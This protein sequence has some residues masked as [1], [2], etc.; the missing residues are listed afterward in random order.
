MSRGFLTEITATTGIPAALYHAGRTLHSFIG[1]VVHYKDNDEKN[2]K[3]S[4]VGSR[5]QRADVFKRVPLLMVDHGSFLDRNLL[6]MDMATLGDLRIS[7]SNGLGPLEPPR[8]GGHTVLVAMGYKRLLPV[9]PSRKY[10]EGKR[11]MGDISTVL[12]WVIFFGL[13]GYGNI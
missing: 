3:K 8:F 13:R 5:S 11:G 4:C 10:V 7:C 6:E 9:F 1:P 12:Y 2:A